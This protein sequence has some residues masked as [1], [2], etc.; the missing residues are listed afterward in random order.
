MLS[1]SLKGRIP[2]HYT[3]DIY[4]NPSVVEQYNDIIEWES[5]LT[6][7]I[8]LKDKNN[9]DFIVFI[10]KTDALRE[11]HGLIVMP[12][13]EKSVISYKIVNDINN[14]V[15]DYPDLDR[16]K[17]YKYNFDINKKDSSPKL[18][19]IIDDESHIIKD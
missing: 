4:G 10:N 13:V 1:K 8:I 12:L 9:Q 15:E 5:K 3:I 19:L 16:L 7:K 18:P 11:D 17:H 2:H 14:V 6:G